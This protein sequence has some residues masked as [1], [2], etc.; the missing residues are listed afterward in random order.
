[1]RRRCIGM[2]VYLVA[3]ATSSWGAGAIESD[4]VTRQVPDSGAAHTTAAPSHTSG[5]VIETMDAG[6]YTYVHV[7]YGDEKSWAA[8]PQFQVEVGDNVIVPAGAAM[9]DYYSKTLD[10][11]FDVVYF[12]AFIAVTGEGGEALTPRGHGDAPE[13]TPGAEIDLA[14]I[15]RAEGGNTVGEIFDEKASFAGQEVTVRGRV[16]KFTPA[17]MGKNWIH[18]RDGTTGAGGANDLTVTSEEMAEVGNTVLVRGVLAI[19]RDFGFGYKY[20]LIIEDANI[21]VE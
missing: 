3:T 10:R 19:D 9:V 2:L 1:V 18:L 17:V 7:D 12:V 20:D 6:R 13:G 4:G 21:T 8:A 5:K 11:T 15:E 16:V 14:A